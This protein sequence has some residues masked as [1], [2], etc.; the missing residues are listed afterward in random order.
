MTLKEYWKALNSHDWFFHFADDSRTLDAGEREFAKL[1]AWSLISPNHTE[2]FAK[3]VAHA[4]TGPAWKT[5]KQPKPEEP[6]E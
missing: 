2:L 6:A 1:K 4:W 3:F 5:V